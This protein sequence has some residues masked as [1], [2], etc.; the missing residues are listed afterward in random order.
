MS[1][2]DFFVNLL[3]EDLEWKE[4]EF[5]LYE[6]KSRRTGELKWT[7]TRVDLIFGHDHRLRALSEAYASDDGEEVFLKNFIKGWIKVMHLDRFDLHRE[8]KL[9]FKTIGGGVLWKR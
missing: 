7:A 9:D 4:K 1:P 3:D 2:F 8:K 5:N 6:G